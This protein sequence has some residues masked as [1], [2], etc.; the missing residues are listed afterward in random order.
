MTTET[1]PAA[2]AA[3]NAQAGAKADPLAG[4]EA[5]AMH[6]G[7]SIVAEA[8]T[9]EAKISLDVKQAPAVAATFGVIGLIAGF[10]LAHIL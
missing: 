5:T 6:L 9:F 2:T 3:G 1:A 4:F 8:K 7:Q 10:I